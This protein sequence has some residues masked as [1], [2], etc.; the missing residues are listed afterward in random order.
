MPFSEKLLLMV[1][2][3]LTISP[4]C[5]VQRWRRNDWRI[6]NTGTYH[7]VIIFWINWAVSEFFILAKEKK[8]R[9]HGISR[10]MGNI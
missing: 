5:H 8:T 2:D 3:S 4:L 10:K 1:R 9:V 7:I 6:N